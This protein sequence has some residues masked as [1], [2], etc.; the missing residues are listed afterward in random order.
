MIITVIMSIQMTS[1]TLKCNFES[2][3]ALNS[4][5][6]GDFLLVIEAIHSS[7]RDSSQAT[8]TE[9]ERGNS[10]HSC[11]LSIHFSIRMFEISEEILILSRSSFRLQMSYCILMLSST[12]ICLQCKYSSS[13]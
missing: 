8:P 9:R 2:S 6:Q 12:K 13:A 5:F 10:S 11:A 4:Y 3:H 7:T 1:K